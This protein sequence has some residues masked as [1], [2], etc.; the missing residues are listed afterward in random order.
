MKDKIRYVP[1]KFFVL[2][3]FVALCAASE[4]R[5]AIPSD[6]L[7]QKLQ[8]RGAVNDFAGILKPEEVAAL[9]NRISQL[10]QKNGSQ[11]AVVILPSLEGGQ[12]EDFANKLFH[13]WGVG[14]K[15]KNNG[16]MLLVALQDR[17]ARIEVGYGLEPILPDALAGRV[18]DEQLFPAFKQGRHAQGLMQAVGRVSDIIERGQPAT[19]QDRQAKRKA[20]KD[21]SAPWVLLFF[22]AIGFGVIGAGIG[23]R[24][25][26]PIVFGS[27][28]GGIPILIL[29]AT[30][31]AFL[32]SF[33]LLAAVIAFSAGWFKG[34]NFLARQFI[35]GCPGTESW[36][37]GNASG[38]GL[39]GGS[40]GSSSDSGFGGGDSG[41]GFG[42]GDSGG[43][44]A[45]GDW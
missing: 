16:I 17:K 3:A 2:T 42:G 41:G 35:P 26:F 39:F 4:A 14:E 18:L 13:K 29:L 6:V 25:I 27:G 32:F 9:Q 34:R 24:Q 30:G 5:A 23:S 28:F 11:F 33:G 21:D 8:P 43:G 38:G 1:K 19:E 45:S 7:L 15:G 31:G 40:S 12:I 10:R 20:K 22:V 36:C 44:G 37:W